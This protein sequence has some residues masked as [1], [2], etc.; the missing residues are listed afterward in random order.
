[1]ESFDPSAATGAAAVTEHLDARGVP[2]EVIEHAE[3]FSAVAEAIAARVDPAA[4]GKTLVLH[5][6]GGY[7]LVVVPANR[8]VDLGRVRAALGAT[9]HLRLATEA[10]MARDFPIYEVGAV[11]PLGPHLPAVEIVDI[12]LLELERGLFA[13]GD[14]RHSVLMPIRD[15]LQMTE[16]RVA[17]V[18]QGRED[19]KDFHSFQ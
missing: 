12:R 8:H 1:M 2:Y 4:A 16:P 11:P 3:T 15:M 13:A 10:E 14:H 6:H 5:D 7:S 9:S 18:C 19:G 17:D